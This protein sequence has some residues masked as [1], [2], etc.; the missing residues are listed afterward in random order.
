MPP[1][2]AGAVDAAPNINTVRMPSGTAQ[3]PSRTGGTGED[4]HSTGE[5]G[6]S[7]TFGGRRM[8]AQ[9]HPLAEWR[10]MTSVTDRATEPRSTEPSRAAL[11]GAPRA[12]G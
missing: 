12:E 4:V 5:L 6:C 3:R 8:N 1:S 2:Q 7:I 10:R 9:E 11:T